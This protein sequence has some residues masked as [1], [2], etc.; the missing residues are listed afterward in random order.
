[1]G[2]SSCG[3]DG[4]V[5]FFELLPTKEGTYRQTEKDITL[6]NVVLSSLVNIPGKHYETFVVG[7]DKK[8]YNTKDIKN[9]HDAGI[10][11][12]QICLTNN[13]K[14]LF[15]GAG[16]ENRPGSIHIF[17]LPLEEIN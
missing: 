5:Y 11:L 16:E 12:S 10:T 17:K 1:M 8:I 6:K 7:N 9:F 14:A 3:M 2:F 13:Q 15:A 4:S